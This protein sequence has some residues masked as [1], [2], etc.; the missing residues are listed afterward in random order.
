MYFIILTFNCIYSLAESNHTSSLKG[1]EMVSFFDG[2]SLIGSLENIEKTGNIVWHHKSS[3]NPLSFEYRAVESILFN[4]SRTSVGYNAD[5][6]LRIKLKNKDFL[7]G[8]IISLNNEELVFSTKFGQT[9]RSKLCDLVSVEFLPASYQVFFDSSYEFKNW[10]KSN[11]KA[12]THEKGSLISVFSGSTGTILPKVDALEVTF[13]AEWQRS[14][15]LALRFFSDSDG[16]SYG[17]E[18]YHL[19]FSNNRINLQSNKKL[20]G[21]TVR[22]TLGSVMVDQLIGVKKANF[23]ISAHRLNKE[24]IV[25]VNGNEVARWKDSSSEYV[26]PDNRGLLLI[27]QGGNSFLRL[28]ELTIAGWSG[29][30]FPVH[31]SSLDNDFET[32]FI[33]FKNANL[34][35]ISKA[36]LP[37][38]L[39]TK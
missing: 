3:K 16:A 32:Q 34:F 39:F 8:T 33:S 38:P 29:E 14:F 13:E 12:W 23:K 28:E 26:Q 22:E 24:F 4:R 37:G 7:C 1:P 30:S 31:Y 10:K 17:S 21:R 19:S 20:K 9:L 2:S 18:G 35:F 5:G 6:Q 25:I 36:G 11:S 27:N 15:Y